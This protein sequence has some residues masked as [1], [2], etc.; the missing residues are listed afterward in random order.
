MRFPGGSSRKHHLSKDDCIEYLNE[1]N[2]TY[3]DWNVLN[4][5]GVKKYSDV[6]LLKNLKKSSQGKNTLVV[7]MHD[8]AFV[9]K[10]YNV[11]EDSILY[12]KEQ[13]YT[14]KTFADIIN[15]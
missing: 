3:V 8:A 10:T 4:N 12:L 15:K 6:Q 14:F 1:I 11:L 5:D 2:Y 13:G 7:L 9:N